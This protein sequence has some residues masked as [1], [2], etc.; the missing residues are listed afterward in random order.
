LARDRLG[1]KPLYW[2]YQHNAFASE[3]QP[4]RAVPE[5]VFTL[6]PAALGSYLRHSCVPA[7][8]ATFREV[9]K[10]P[11]GERIEVTLLDV[12][13]HVYWD[14]PAIARNRQVNQTRLRF[15][16]V[17]DELDVLLADAVKR[18]MVSDVPLG[19]FLSGGIDSSLVVALMRKTSNS[20]VKTFSI[21]FREEAYNEADHARRV[22]EQLGSEHTELILSAA[23]AQAVVLKLPA[24]YDEPFADS[25]QIQTYLV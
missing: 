3:L 7:P 20:R 2:S 10:L 23:E 9:N 4:L 5:F 11:P 1:I 21:G 22:A 16:D 6:D 8:R 19:A 15:D 17:V 12:R 18:Q 13:H 24:I 14:L 25:S